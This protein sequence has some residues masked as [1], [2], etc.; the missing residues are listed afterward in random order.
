MSAARSCFEQV[1]DVAVVGSG[2]AGF[3]AATR[4]A[5]AGRRVL[6]IGPRGD[7]LWESGRAFGF[8]AGEAGSPRWRSF[9]ARLEARGGAREG[10]VDG[11][12]AEVRATDELAASRA[13]VLYYA[14]P[15]AAEL[16]DDRLAALILATKTGP[17][18]VAARQWVDATERGDLIRLVQ[19]A[20]RPR[21][22]GGL[23][24]YAVFRLDAP[25][26]LGRQELDAAAGV[27][28]RL[29]LEPSVWPAEVRLKVELDGEP[30]EPLRALLPALRRVRELHPELSDAGVVS[31]SSIEPLPHYGAEAGVLEAAGNVACAA[32]GLSGGAFGGLA[33]RYALGE[34]A[35]GRLEELPPHEPARDAFTR[36][37]AEPAWRETLR[38]DVGV[39]GVGTG[40]ALSVIA[41]A[42]AGARVLGI[43]PL[44]FAGGIGTGGGIHS[45]YFGVTGG[46]Q[47]EVDR[48][49]AEAAPCFAKPEHMDGFHPDAKRL[50]L[51]EMLAESGAR[52]LTGALLFGCEKEGGR[53]RA[54]HVAVS[55]GA[56]RVE[57]AGWV[58]ATGDGDLCALAGADFTY[59]RAGDGLPHA[60]SQSSGR[61]EPDGKGGCRMRIVNYDA[62]WV[63]PLDAEDLTRARLTGI[64]QYVRERHEEP[65]R[66]TYIAAALGIRQGRQVATDYAITFADQMAR[67]SFP[68]AIGYQACHMDNH[69]VDYE[70]EDDES[71]FWTWFCRSWRTDLACEIPYRALLPRG[72]DNVWLAC[73]AL[74]VTV[75][76]HYSLRMQ[77]DMQ[78]IGE[79]AGCAAALAVASG[80]GSRGVDPAQLRARLS[81][82]GALDLAEADRP[83]PFRGC[84]SA[85]NW[86]RAP[87]S[88]ELVRDGLQALAEGRAVPE[89]YHVAEAGNAVRET[90]KKA[91]RDGSPRVSWLAAGICARWGDP[92]AEPR[93]IEAVR[94]REYGFDRP[95]EE[96][97]GKLKGSQ[98]AWPEANNRLVP[99]WL[100]AVSLLRMCGTERCLG[101]LQELASEPF[102]PLNAR[103]A[104]AL[105][106][107]RL[108]QRKA[109][110]DTAALP[111]ILELLAAGTVTGAYGLPQR[112]LGE[113][114]EH[115]RQAGAGTRVAGERLMREPGDGRVLDGVTPR[116][117]HLWQLHLVL[118]RL[119][120]ALG[121]APQPEAKRYLEDP[122]AFVRR[123]FAAAVKA[124]TG[125]E[126]GA[127]P[128]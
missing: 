86:F 9:L 68:D 70:F 91:L 10:R 120:A 75:A 35:A 87:A 63:D 85:A 57:A 52:V 84:V 34:R 38:A 36:R 7:L 93:L 127:L 74:G 37:I 118:A 100:L 24:L 90:V 17:R 15:V 128:G 89:L 113:I 54:G 79:A 125:A 97:A 122:R 41:A 71:L 58:D 78:R 73:R 104:V 110:R 108:V 60:Y 124:R 4:L 112:T 48:R 92:E 25:A 96:A 1:H 66:P 55:G 21:A 46:L 82:T 20:A 88:E 59:G 101:A 111:A 40:G 32:P 3:A 27:K 117:S 116:E 67:R 8:E 51:A 16:A 99:N 72:L 49:V 42:R 119:R 30:D 56:V 44:A 76:A 121:L 102:L 83:G 39:A 80:G 45:Y 64:R 6:L 12:V 126:V 29:T 61:V 107:E 115:A 2:Y 81:A 33:E 31:H 53:V 77:R 5:E 98:R 106:L 103:T 26:K 105:T 11:A 22:A 13:A 43:E 94:S 95:D 47:A 114:A 50:V 69:A 19:P 62:G 65:E 28:G 23:T 109:V 18:R 123:A 14:W